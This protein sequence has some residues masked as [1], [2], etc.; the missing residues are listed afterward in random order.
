MLGRRC[1]AMP[2]P[3]LPRLG[4]FESL[5]VLRDVAAPTLAK[6][7]LR[8]RKPMEASAE[9]LALD[10]VAVRRMTRLRDRYGAGPVVL[11]L[12]FR[13]QALVLTRTDAQR[14]LAGTPEPFKAASSEK[15]AALSHFQ[16]EGVL[17]SHGEAR[18]ERRVLNE[19]VL[20][21]A[22]PVH[23]LAPRF[24]QILQQEMEE[25]L[26]RSG[27]ELDWNGFIA[28][29]Y[30][31]VRRIAFGD[32]ARDDDALTD[33]LTK[34]RKDGNWAFA[35]PKRK[36]LRKRFL[37][38]LEG[39]I[40]AAPTDSLG[41]QLRLSPKG[42]N[43][44]PTQQPPQWLFA[45][46]PA[47]MAT[48]RALALLATHPQA[49]GDARR[50]ASRGDLADL[51]F[52]RTVLLESVR[53]WPTTPAILRQSTAPTDWGG[54]ILPEGAGLLIFAPYFNRD[55]QL[56]FADRFAP[57]IWD[58]EPLAAVPGVVPF[59]DGPAFCP[60]RNLVLLL[61]A[62]ALGILAGRTAG[63]LDPDRLDPTRPLPSALDNFTLKFALTDRA[64]I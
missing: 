13:R 28:A 15:R 47:A 51:P 49:M 11:G 5:A 45:F 35:R 63:L 39:Y 32:S 14:V 56:P 36:R 60:G 37:S 42:P 57:E 8:R 19:R 62:A 58:G 2:S 34:L 17:A 48:F 20:Q 41:G 64:Q 4:F 25:L 43:A 50:E 24:I 18:A 59:S 27:P 16:P 6:G 1:S 29:W 44:A 30:R 7:V 53:L 55:P 12:P 23:G 52:L 9:W 22:C 54:R 61:G 3:T 31:V 10:R 40:K 33:M 46:E 26:R 21:T 38:R